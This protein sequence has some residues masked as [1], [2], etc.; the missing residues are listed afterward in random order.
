[1]SQGL[2]KKIEK[3]REKMRGSIDDH[4][5]DATERRNRKSRRSRSFL[6]RRISGEAEGLHKKSFKYQR[7]TAAAK[8]PEFIKKVTGEYILCPGSNQKKGLC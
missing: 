7:T 5:K 6:I 8:K 2:G 3:K 1:M 4:A